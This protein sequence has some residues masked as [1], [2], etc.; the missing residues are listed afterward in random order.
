MTMQA[1]ERI[2]S[3]IPTPEDIDAQISMHQGEIDY[4]REE[5]SK[6]RKLKTTINKFA[7]QVAEL[8]FGAQTNGDPQ[9]EL[10]TATKES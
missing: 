10:A 8:P 3:I 2:P 9:P 5:I 7:D 4:N 6:L 1:R